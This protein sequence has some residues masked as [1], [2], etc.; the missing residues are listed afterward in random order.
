MVPPRSHYHPSSLVPSAGLHSEIRF[1]ADPRECGY[2][3]QSTS[4]ERDLPAAEILSHIWRRRSLMSFGAACLRSG[5]VVYVCVCVSAGKPSGVAWEKK[6]SSSNALQRG[7]TKKG[8]RKF[9][10]YQGNQ[11]EIARFCGMPRLAPTC[12][13]VRQSLIAQRVRK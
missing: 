9:T 10:E 6:T 5:T 7:S 11:N 3:A 1:V 8:L 4:W 12:I 2:A 13:Y